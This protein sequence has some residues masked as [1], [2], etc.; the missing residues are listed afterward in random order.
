MKLKVVL[1][2]MVM[3][4]FFSSLC[5]GVGLVGVLKG[6]GVRVKLGCRLVF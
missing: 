2:V 1:C 5:G 6:L 4:W 3:W